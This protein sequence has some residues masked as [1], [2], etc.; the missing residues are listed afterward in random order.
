MGSD[1]PDQSNNYNSLILEHYKNYNY[2]DIKF[3][4][5]CCVHKN[6]GMNEFIYKL[7]ANILN[8][9]PP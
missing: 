7:N 6:E 5:H 3:K 9:N 8:S 2:K 4:A 1:S